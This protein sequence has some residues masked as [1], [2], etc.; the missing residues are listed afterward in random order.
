MELRSYTLVQLLPA[1]TL[2]LFA[3]FCKIIGQALQSSLCHIFHKVGA[4]EILSLAEKAFW[5]KG[6]DQCNG[7]WSKMPCSGVP[8]R[9]DWQCEPEPTILCTEVE[10]WR[11]VQG[12]V[13][14]RPKCHSGILFRLHTPFKPGN[15]IS[16]SRKTQFFSSLPCKPPKLRKHDYILKPYKP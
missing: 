1:Q 6:S 7:D 9:P 13:C 15:R 8:D 10:P 5:G 3:S 12:M 14:L 11:S 4:G 2:F 16:L